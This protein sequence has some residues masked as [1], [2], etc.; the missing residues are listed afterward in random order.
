M[1]SRILHKIEKEYGEATELEP[2]PGNF[3]SILD[4]ESNYDKLNEVITT[5]IQAMVPS[6]HD[7][8]GSTAR[9]G[10]FSFP[11]SSDEKTKISGL[12]FE[13]AKTFGSLRK[14]K[15]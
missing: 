13:C 4:L 1:L 15:K 2:K 8:S 12:R 3:V 14:N 6:D 10:R 7:Y 9:H 11:F 5:T